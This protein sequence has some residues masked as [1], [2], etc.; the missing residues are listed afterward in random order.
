MKP[1]LFEKCDECGIGPASGGGDD[2]ACRASW[3]RSRSFR[4][5][6]TT[7]PFYAQTPAACVNGTAQRAIGRCAS[8]DGRDPVTER[9]AV[10][11]TPRPR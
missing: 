8:I 9:I 7:R 10:K 2:P 1:L 11:R 6:S 4:P 5:T 3:F